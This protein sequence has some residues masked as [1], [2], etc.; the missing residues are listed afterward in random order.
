MLREIDIDGYDFKVDENG[1]IKEW[2]EEWSALNTG[3]YVEDSFLDKT[4]E[5][6]RDY[7][8][9]LLGFMFVPPIIMVLII[10]CLMEI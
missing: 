2:N 1:I 10:L 3:S 4:L 7:R 6:F 8:R 5:Y 9:Q